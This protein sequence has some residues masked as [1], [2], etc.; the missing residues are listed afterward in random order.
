MCTVNV[1]L[2]CIFFMQ[3]SWSDKMVER[4]R[5]V[6]KQDRKKGVQDELTPTVK[7]PKKQTVLLSRYPVT[8]ALAG[9]LV[10]VA[11]EAWKKT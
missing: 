5:N 8:F 2:L 10:E 9:N 7:K 1:S 11:E 4:T 6:I 3:Q